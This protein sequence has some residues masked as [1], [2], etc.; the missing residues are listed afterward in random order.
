MNGFIAC[1]I[2]IFFNTKQL[3]EAENKLLYIVHLKAF[4]FKLHNVLLFKYVYVYICVCVC[5]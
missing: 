2:S 5:V 1:D 3:L 4:L